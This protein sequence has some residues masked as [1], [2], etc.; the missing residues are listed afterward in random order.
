MRNCTNVGEDLVITGLTGST[1]GQSDTKKV[2]HNKVIVFRLL[3]HYHVSRVVRNLSFVRNVV[4]TL[5]TEL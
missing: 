5:P 3:G 2:V 1:C 4:L